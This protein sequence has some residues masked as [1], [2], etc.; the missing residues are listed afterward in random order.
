MLSRHRGG[1]GR[2][3]VWV[4][5]RDTCGL[6]LVFAVDEL[7]IQYLSFVFIIFFFDACGLGVTHHLLCIHI[8]YHGI[9]G[10]GKALLL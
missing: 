10:Q 9:L 4:A 1:G 5:G 3:L 2:F 7:E 6:Y 8:D